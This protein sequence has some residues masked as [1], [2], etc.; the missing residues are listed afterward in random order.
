[1][2]KLVGV[3]LTLGGVAGVLYSWVDEQRNK[4]IRLDMFLLF[5]QK[6][7]YVMKREKVKVMDYFQRVIELDNP[8]QIYRN[9]LLQMALTEI[10]Q[11]L[12]T[13][14]YPSGQMVWEEVFQEEK[15][16]W[17]LDPEIFQMIVQAGNGFFGR[18]REENVSFLEKSIKE[19]EEQQV[20]LKQK[21][22][23]ERKVWV[24]VGML[25]TMML[26]ILFL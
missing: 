9:E 11:R 8:L 15:Q 23:Q 3:F 6:S 13:N 22:A 17:N 21:N 19:L 12:S 10:L 18:S 26:V 14:T 24:P 1:M 5:L 2:W 20:K 25:G 16:S 7:L 4:Q